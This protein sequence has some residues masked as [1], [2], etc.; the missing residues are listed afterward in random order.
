[1]SGLRDLDDKIVP[2]VA[3]ALDRVARLF[4]KAPEP[5]GPLPVILRLRRVDDRWTAAGPLALLRDVPQLGAL[6][7]GALLLTNGITWR[8]RHDPARPPGQAAESPAP[9]EETIPDD[10]TLG[11]DLGE[12]VSDYVKTTQTRLRTAMPGSPDGTVVAVVSFA[13]YRT[14]EQVAEAVGTLQV[15]RI[16]Y[17]VPL[18]LPEGPI[19]E[20]AVQDVVADTKREFRRLAAERD[21]EAKELRKVAATIENDPAQKA[22]DLRN[23]AIA[24]REVK[25]L[26]GPCACI[27]GVVVRARLR[28]L[29]DALNLTA[30]R[31]I[32]VSNVDAK[33]EDFTFTALLP[34]DKRVVTGGNR[35]A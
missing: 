9:G 18:P 8:V 33:V 35:G 23:A 21:A 32:D 14:P 13:G 31:A 7:I 10:G 26:R 1:M 28:L 17:R 3:E 27:Y 11:P 4:P 6:L 29:T 12:R 15:H 24:D 30:I 19:K 20:A 2:R 25:L 34:E 5:T 16:L 22:E